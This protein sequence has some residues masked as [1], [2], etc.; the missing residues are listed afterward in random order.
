METG[1]K[2]KQSILPFKMF[3][4]WYCSEVKADS[5]STFEMT[6]QEN[7]TAFIYNTSHILGS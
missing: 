5:K 1:Q 4:A 7:F 6:L 3:S 2:V